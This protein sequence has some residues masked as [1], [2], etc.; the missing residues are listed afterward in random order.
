MLELLVNEGD[1]V[2][3]L[4]SYQAGTALTNLADMTTL[5]FKG[6]V[7]EI[8]V[9]KLQEGM[10]AHIKIGALPDAKVEGRVYKIAPKSKT[11]EGATLFD[12]EIELLP[13]QGRRCCAPATRRTPRSPS[14]RRRTCCS[15][16]ERLVTFADGKATIELPAAGRRPADQEGDQDRALGRHERRGGRGP[17]GEGPRR[18][19]AAEEDRVAPPRQAPE[20][21]MT[22]LSFLRQMLQDVRHQKLR[23]AL[24]LFGI[25]WGTVSVA[26]LVA[27]GEGL[28]GRIEKN[29]RG[30]RREHRDRLARAH[31]AA[32]AGPRQGPPDQG[33]RGGPRGPAPRDPGGALLGRVRA[34]QSTFRRERARITPGMSATNPVFAVMRN[35]IPARAA[36][37]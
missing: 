11:A 21:A 34:Q 4:T 13:G 30:P 9:G 20:D 5:I 12:V 3:P 1:P 17:A 29:Q 10:P 27:F 16:P 35:L 28:Q 31:R 24:T 32:L 18:R 33:H 14:A 7:D 36:A 19:A 2:V 37:T 25:T 8:D 15:L 23:T 26:L 22:S 6:T